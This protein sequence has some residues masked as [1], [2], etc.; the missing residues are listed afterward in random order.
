M[1]ALPSVSEV[2]PWVQSLLDLRRTPLEHRVAASNL[3]L[4]YARAYARA[5]G[6]DEARAIVVAFESLRNA[7]G[8]D[9][10]VESLRAVGI[11]PWESVEAVEEE[12]KRDAEER[13]EPRRHLSLVPWG[14]PS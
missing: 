3:V 1:S 11:D 9:A 6:L 8:E 13:A 2:A 5:E 14:E 7:H 12:E 10:A 4:A